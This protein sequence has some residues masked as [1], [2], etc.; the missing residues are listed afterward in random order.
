LSVV[1]GSWGE[2]SMTSAKGTAS[3]SLLNHLPRE[4]P[5]FLVSLGLATGGEKEKYY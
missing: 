1:K 2:E 3:A 5:P 4:K